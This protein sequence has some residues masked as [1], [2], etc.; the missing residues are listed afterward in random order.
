M[1]EVIKEQLSFLSS[2]KKKL[3]KKIKLFMKKIVNL[4]FCTLLK[5]DKQKLKNLIFV[6]IRKLQKIYLK[7]NKFIIIE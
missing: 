1:I 6:M 7:N 4:I 2:S 5:R 3:F